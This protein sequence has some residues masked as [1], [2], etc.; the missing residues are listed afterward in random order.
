MT[1]PD[2]RREMLT[3]VEAAI[4]YHP[5]SLQKRIGPSGLG[6]PCSRKLGFRLAQ[7]GSSAVR[8]AAWRPT[9]GTAVH[10]WLTVAFNM[11]NDNYP[12]DKPR[13]LTDIRVPVGEIDG[14]MIDGSLDLYD[15]YTGTVVDWKI[16]GP[17]SIAD[18]KR[19][20]PGVEYQVQVHAYGRGITS[21][22]LVCNHVGILF[23]P[24]N[25]ELADSYYWTEPFDE[26]IAIAALERAS[27][28]ALT[29]RLLGAAEVLPQLETANDHCTW[30]S[31]FKP[32]T[33]DLARACPGDPGMSVR[34]DQFT[35]LIASK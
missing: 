5:R 8:A 26:S 11:D 2:Y 34:S 27:A 19:H 28:I 31:W 33:T 13:W 14:E 21:L 4:N 15:I 7:T 30:C 17:T 3:V 20:G 9:V 10:T 6:T 25:G 18:K 22:N 35:D 12:L 29:V 32:G 16:P 1:N 24:S 23:M